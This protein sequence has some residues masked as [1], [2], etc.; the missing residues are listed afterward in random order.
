MQLSKGIDVA[1]GRLVRTFSRLLFATLFATG[2]ALS[3]AADSDV[4]R[5]QVAPE[6]DRASVVLEA[7]IV[8]GSKVKL[9]LLDEKLELN[10]PYG[11]LQIPV[12]EIRQIDVAW[13]IPDEDVRKIDAAIIQLGSPEFPR[14]RAAAEELAAFGEKAYPALRK[15]V[16][17]NNPEDKA[18]KNADAEIYRR[19]TE[20]VEKLRE[21]VPEDRLEV[22][23]NDVVHTADSKI[24]G[25]LTASALKVKTLAFGEQQLKLTD[26]RNL[27]SPDAPE[28]DLANALPDPGSMAAI[29]GNIG[30]TYVFRVTGAPAGSGGIFGAGVY[31]TDSRLAVSAVHAGILKPGQTGNVKVT[32]MGQVANYPA[33]TQNGIT[34]NAYGPYPGYRIGK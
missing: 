34:S 8:D 32:L 28:S 30:Q 6:K 22:P 17:L 12:S 29:Q 25:R 24:A 1:A 2:G 14:R 19:A 13:R 7:R 31:T 26:V 33:S 20:L 18:N 16:K 21:S 15:A 10:T 23:E 27:R 9:T 4:P 5:K 11:K 3:L